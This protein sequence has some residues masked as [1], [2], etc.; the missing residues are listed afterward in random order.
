VNKKKDYQIPVYD[1]SGSRFH[2]NLQ[3]DRLRKTEGK[4]RTLETYIKVALK[5]PE[6][7]SLTC[8][9]TLKMCMRRSEQR[10]KEMDFKKA[11]FKGIGMT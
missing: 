5:L 11:Q 9:T 8:L 4:K 3:K 7:L 6:T 10:I 1:L 2:P